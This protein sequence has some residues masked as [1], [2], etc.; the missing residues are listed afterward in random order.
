MR[1]ITHTRYI[2]HNKF[3]YIPVDNCRLSSV[4]PYVLHTVLRADRGCCHTFPL[5]S[6]IVYQRNPTNTHNVSPVVQRITLVRYR[7]GDPCT[8]KKKQKKNPD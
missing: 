4:H 1:Q 7:Q 2:P 8:Q 6:G 3:Q 5:L